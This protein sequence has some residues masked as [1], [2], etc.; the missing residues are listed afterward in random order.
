MPEPQRM[1]PS[2]NFEQKGAVADLQSASVVHVSHSPPLPH[3]ARG[4][5]ARTSATSQRDLRERIIRSALLTEECGTRNI[6]LATAAG[7]EGQIAL[8]ARFD[9]LPKAVYL[10]LFGDPLPF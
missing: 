5:T 9:P 3:P 2:L 8:R 10:C 7:W 1:L 4:S 6:V